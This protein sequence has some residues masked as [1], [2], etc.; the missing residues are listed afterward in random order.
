MCIGCSGKQNRRVLIQNRYV[1]RMFR[2]IEQAC[3]N[4][5]Q[6]CV[7]GVR[8]I[9]QACTNSKQVCIQGV[10]ENRT[11]VYY[12]KIG[13]CIGCSEKQNRRVLIQNRYVYKVFRKIE[14]ACTNSKWVCVQGVPEN[15]TGLFYFKRCAC[16]LL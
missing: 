3:T 2:K 15:R 13:M 16:M 8:K 14:Q 1:Y 10:P 9:E 11:G 5:K 4:S 7:Q 6:V 12:F